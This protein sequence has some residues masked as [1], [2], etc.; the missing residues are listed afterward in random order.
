V[1]T[2]NMYKK[3]CSKRKSNG[4]PKKKKKKKTAKRFVR[5]RGMEEELELGQ[6]E[7]SQKRRGGDKKKSAVSNRKIGKVKEK[8]TESP[9]RWEHDLRKAIPRSR[10]GA[11]TFEDGMPRSEC[12]EKAPLPGMFDGWNPNKKRAGWT[13]PKDLAWVTKSTNNDNGR[14]NQTECTKQGGAEK[15]QNWKAY[16]FYKKS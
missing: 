9:K 13:S 11:E 3:H 10:G 15:I 7:N 6:R 5:K 1:K 8:Y 12:A 2:E 4:D 16:A 14:G